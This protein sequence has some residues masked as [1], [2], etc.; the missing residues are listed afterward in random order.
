MKISFDSSMLRTVAYMNRKHYERL[1]IKL[2]CVCVCVRACG[3][4][5]VS[6]IL[7]LLFYPQTF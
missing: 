4:F 6:S 1:E 5:I 2:V 7:D 3:G